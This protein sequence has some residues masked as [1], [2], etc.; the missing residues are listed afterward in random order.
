MTP[1]VQLA[2]HGLEPIYQ[3]SVVNEGQCIGQS[4]KF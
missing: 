4:S 3:D 1:A 2:Q